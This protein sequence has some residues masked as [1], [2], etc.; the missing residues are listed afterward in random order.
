LHLTRA[1]R[2]TL[3]RLRL[4]DRLGGDAV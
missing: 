3:L 2:P 1:A 4:R